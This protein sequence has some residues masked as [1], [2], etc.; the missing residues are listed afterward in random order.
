MKS[1]EI[2]QEVGESRLV[3]IIKRLVAMKMDNSNEIQVRDFSQYG[4]P[5]CRVT[6][7]QE[8]G[9]YTVETSRG[10]RRV[11]FDDLDL[12]AIEIYNYLYDFRHAF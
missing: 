11:M 7:H 1:H 2:D 10:R 9:V 8:T 6:Y 5:V 3:A 4:I 12:C